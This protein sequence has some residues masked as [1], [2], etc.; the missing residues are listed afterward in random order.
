MATPILA[1]VQPV[2]MISPLPPRSPSLYTLEDDLQ[3]LPDSAEM[4]TPEEQAEFAADLEAGLIAAVHKRDRVGWF[5][6]HIE[7]QTALAAA[8]IKRLQA[9]KQFFEASLERIEAS[10]ARGMR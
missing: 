6:A 10:A 8:E 4:V 2:E 7:G 1:L 9:R 5:M 3:A